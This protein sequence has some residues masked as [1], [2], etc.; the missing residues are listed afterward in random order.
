MIKEP[1]MTDINTP[2]SQP[3]IVQ[4]TPVAQQP[5]QAPNNSQQKQAIDPRK[6]PLFIGLAIFAGLFVLFMLWFLFFGGNKNETVQKVA[7]AVVPQII[8]NTVVITPTPAP[9][10][11]VTGTIDFEGYA[12]TDSYIAISERMQGRTDFR[13]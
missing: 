5:S 12:P 6:N 10:T 1:Y 13:D 3:Q 4:N 9:A 7:H 11:T 8:T 2:Q